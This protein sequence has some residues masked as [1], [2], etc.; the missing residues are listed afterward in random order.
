M[1]RSLRL[2]GQPHVELWLAHQDRRSPLHAEFSR[3]TTAP[4]P[5]VDPRAT[6]TLA[7]VVDEKPAEIAFSGVQLDVSSERKELR[8]RGDD[9]APHVSAATRDA[10]EA[11]R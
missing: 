11:I 3:L 2:A 10:A 4:D 6:N 9:P 5:D 7:G 1:N 8:I